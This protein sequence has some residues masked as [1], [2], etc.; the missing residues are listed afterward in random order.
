MAEQFQPANWPVIG[1]AGNNQD[2]IGLSWI[3]DHEPAPGV[4][5]EGK[6]CDDCKGANKDATFLHPLPDHAMW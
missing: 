3:V 6:Q 1:L 2:G 5:G 4:G